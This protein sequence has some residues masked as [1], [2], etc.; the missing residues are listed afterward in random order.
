MILT[1]GKVLVIGQYKKFNRNILRDI[2]PYLDYLSR[3]ESSV[4][5][6]SAT[7]YK[8]EWSII[9]VTFPSL[10]TLAAG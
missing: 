10:A 5:A 8:W 4:E 3:C 7:L 1:Q 9:P 6:D 2:K